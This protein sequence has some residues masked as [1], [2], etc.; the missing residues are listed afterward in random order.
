MREQPELTPAVLMR[1]P[2]I[3]KFIC[4]LLFDTAE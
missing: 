4:P 3:F 2:A 1:T